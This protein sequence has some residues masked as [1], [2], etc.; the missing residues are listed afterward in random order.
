MKL[1]LSILTLSVFFVINTFAQITSPA[2]N[3]IINSNC[4]PASVTFTNVL[5]TTN[6]YT[7]NH[8]WTFDNG[9]TSTS[10][11][12]SPET[13]T[14]SGV[15]KIID[16]AFVLEPVTNTYVKKITVNSATC[17]D[18]FNPID[19]YLTITDNTGDVDI[20]PIQ[21][22]LPI[23]VIFNYTQTVNGFLLMPNT[24]Y[25]IHVQDDDAISNGIPGPADC[26]IVSFNSNSSQT[27]FTLTN[28]GLTLSVELIRINGL[29][30]TDTIVTATQFT[31]NPLPIVTVNSGTICNGASL[32][33]TP[34]GAISYTFS[35]GAS[36]VSPTTTTNYTIT[37]SDANNCSNT[38]VSSVSVNQLPTITASTNNTLV[39]V[40][41]SA[42]LSA[43]GATSYTWNTNAT[44]T[45]I[46][47]SPT[48]TTT[49]TV[50]GTDVNGCVNSTTI[51]Q[52]VSVCTDIDN[53][54]L[55]IASSN[56]NVYPNPSTG[57]F[58]LELMFDSKIEI[59]DVLGKVII[60][61]SLT[62]GKNAI[63]LSKYGNGIYMLS[64]SNNGLISKT[65]I[66]KE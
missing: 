32:T 17:T 51:T 19:L 5:Q 45:I 9:N 47:V 50:N 28:G 6:T 56:I 4:V 25:S 20:S 46:A 64:L 33:L 10:S 55:L 26:G 31:V 8:N 18:P 54:A 66:I 14:N 52:D 11:N 15:F 40:G 36:V 42:D 58:T 61:Q 22:N 16:T 7:I 48:I 34:N 60:T 30:V 1:K 39:C 57:M 37:G 53:L 43:S 2:Y 13:Y 3:A 41:Q 65:K 44:G 49:Y 24:S 62:K 29:S 12:P 23:P 63:D 27:T 21:F 35:S 59:T 38:V